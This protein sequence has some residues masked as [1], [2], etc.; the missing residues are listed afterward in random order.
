MNGALIQPAEERRLFEQL[1]EYYKKLY[2]GIGFRKMEAVLKPE[3][4]GDIV[5]TYPGEETEATFNEEVELIAESIK[6]GYDTPLVILRKPKE[7]RDIILDGHRRLKVAFDKKIGWK[8]LVM[9][10]DRE[11]QFGIEKMARG[12]VKDL[13]RKKNNKA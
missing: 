6:H 11:I 12:K 13:F 1:V 8:A 5:Y 7:N 9:V 10:P 4:I 3:E 2:P